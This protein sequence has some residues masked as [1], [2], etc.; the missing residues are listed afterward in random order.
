M[1]RIACAFVPRFELALRA[2]G[3]PGLWDRP[4][5]VVDLAGRPPRLSCV[6]PAAERLGIQTGEIAARARA[7]LPELACLAPE[8]VLHRKAEREVL[9]ALATLA[10][11]LDADG[12]GAFFLGLDGLE[13][14]WPD[15]A[16]LRQRLQA[17]FADLQLPARCAF[18]DTPFAAWVAAQH[19]QGARALD[20]VRLTELD[21]SEPA[22][23]LCGVLGLR[24][25]GALSRLPSGTLATRLG[26]EGARLERLCQGEGFAA[27][28]SARHLPRAPEAVELEL[29]LPL[30]GLEPLLFALQSLLLRLLAQ[31]GAE[32]QALTELTVEVRLDDRTC[33][34]Q[35]FTPVRP[36]LEAAALLDLLRLWL[37]GRPFRSQVACLKLIA[38]QVGAA[39]ATQLSLWRQREEQSASALEAAL[40]R[41]TAAFGPQAVLRPQLCDTHR[42]E[43][44]LRWLPAGEA[45]PAAAPALVAARFVGAP[46]TLALRQIDPPERISI[47]PGPALK[48]QGQPAV[49]MLR[50]EGPQRLCGEWWADRFDRSYYWVRLAGGALAWIFRDEATG[51]VYLQA[52]GD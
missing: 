3:D 2:R 39:T 1:G 26:A 36:T 22:R 25:A 35:R 16:T 51:N 40:A 38:S 44:R 34:A 47:L 13:R 23:E 37:E 27:W 30:E 5:A 33:S 45:P 19:G 12:R 31:V 28:P 50:T 24:S 9:A 11:R 43:A 20:A 29:D 18:A 49:S 48:R 46:L 7:R 8:V 52:V 42:P 32:R 15:E 10:P 6:T 14:L 4:A 17:I 41:L 21:L